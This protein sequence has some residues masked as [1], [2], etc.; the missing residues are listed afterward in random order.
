MKTSDKGID[1]IKKHEGDL[2][3]HAVNV[4][5]IGRTPKRQLM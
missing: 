3:H 2:K 4:L 5:T 1:L